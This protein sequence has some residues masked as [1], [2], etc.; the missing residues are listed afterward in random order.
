MLS[1]KNKTEQIL[2]YLMELIQTGQMPPNKIMPSQHQLMKRFECSR[3]IIAAAYKKL[4]FL[5]AV[6]SISKRGYFVSENFHNLIKPLSFLLGVSRQD[7]YEIKNVDTLPDW[8]TKKHIIFTNGFRTF[9]KNYFKED[10]LIAES[11]IFLSLKCVS[12]KE[13]INLNIPITDLLIR[14]KI[15]TNV[16]Y[17]IEF[18][19][20]IKFGANPSVAVIFYGYDAD[21]ICI[22]GKFYVDPENFKFYHQEFSLN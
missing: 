19:K 17:Q 4:E 6:Y 1:D 15:L 18:E 5:G 3:N 13:N 9:F 12:K 21:S 8:A 22:D 2:E 14:R 11:E 20:I 10:K 7:G 16:V